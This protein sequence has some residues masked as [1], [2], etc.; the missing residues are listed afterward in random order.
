MDWSKWEDVMARLEHMDCHRRVGDVVDSYLIIC[1]NFYGCF[2]FPDTLWIYLTD[3]LACW[4]VTFWFFLGS[5]KPTA[6]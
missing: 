4:R 6:M 3:A 2:F 1:L 5:T